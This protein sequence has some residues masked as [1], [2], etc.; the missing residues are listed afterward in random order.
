M[1]RPL[2]LGQ[3]PPDLVCAMAL[4]LAHH[5]DLVVSLE[6]VTLKDQRLQPVATHADWLGRDD[7]LEVVTQEY[8]RAR[9]EVVAANARWGGTGWLTA[10]TVRV[11]EAAKAR[12]LHAKARGHALLG[13][14]GA[15]TKA[16]AAGFRSCVD[17]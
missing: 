4:G 3:F 12:A 1:K 9:R 2:I 15:F 16:G 17:E 5:P 10:G 7:P 8:L 11:R 6:A 13:E 14:R